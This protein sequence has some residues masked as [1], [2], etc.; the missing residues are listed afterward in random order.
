MRF[1]QLL[2]ENARDCWR[3]HYLDYHNLKAELKGHARAHAH[4]PAA[5]GVA[6]P[7]SPHDATNLDPWA[8]LGVARGSDAGLWLAT[9]GEERFLVALQREIA[10]V[11][12]LLCLLAG[13]G[14][15]SSEGLVAPRSLHKQHLK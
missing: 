15:L 3:A 6:S 5:A 1:E 11:G 13:R 9:S 4:E 2:Q 14:G 12:A 8:T 10:K 7:R